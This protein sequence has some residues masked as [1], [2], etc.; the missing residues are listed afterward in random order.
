M[1]GAPLPGLD[2][3]GADQLPHFSDQL[4]PAGQFVIHLGCV[5][6]AAEV[7]LS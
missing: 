1:S 7:S 6:M 2:D 4:P 3:S 5:Y